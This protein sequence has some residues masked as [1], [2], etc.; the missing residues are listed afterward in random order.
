VLGVVGAA[1]GGARGPLRADRFDRFQRVAGALEA[2]PRGGWPAGHAVCHAL[3]NGVPRVVY[4]AVAAA[5]PAALA[6]AARRLVA[7][8]GPLAALVAPGVADV[9]AARAVAAAVAAAAEERGGEP[10]LVWLDAPDGADEAAL[11]AHAGAVGAD[12]ARVRLVAPWVA[13]LSPGRRQA[14]RLPGACL[15]APLGLG[16]AGALRGVHDLAPGLP[17][18]AIRRLRAAGCDVLVAAGPRRQVALAGPP[19][20]PWRPAPPGDGAPPDAAG[21]PPTARDLA[22][23]VAAALETAC[24]PLAVGAAPTASLCRTLERQARTALEPL[25]R[26]GR[27]TAYALRC[28]LERQPDGGLAPV[29]EVGLRLPDRVREVVVRAGPWRV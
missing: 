25:R 1:P 19:P 15:V 26:A 6:E 18:D 20:R 13:T 17:P 23:E 5:T 8:E 28:E 24:T 4:L 2:A 22:G 3:L 29:V 27:V 16:V 14:E 11:L 21:A 12:G 10:P 7:D 9:A